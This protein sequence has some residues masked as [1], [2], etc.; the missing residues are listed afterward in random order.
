MSRIVEA[1]QRMLDAWPDGPFK[2]N[3]QRVWDHHERQGTLKGNLE[4]AA[5]LKSSLGS[6]R[7]PF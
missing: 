6:S 2:R 5:I 4:R 3:C 7:R 1:Y